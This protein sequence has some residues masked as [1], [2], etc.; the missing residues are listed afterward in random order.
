MIAYAVEGLGPSASELPGLA[1]R[2]V[3]TGVAVAALFASVGLAAASLTSRKAIAGIVVVLLFL[4]PGIVAAILIESGGA[5]DELSL[6]GLF[7]LPT[8]LA[9]RVFGE[10]PT[11][12]AAIGRLSTALVV[13]GVVAWTTAGAVVTWVAYRRIEARS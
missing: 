7:G 8:E 9:L 6:L 3:V 2:I 4:V 1:L 13:A 5:P 12:G 10:D 11:D